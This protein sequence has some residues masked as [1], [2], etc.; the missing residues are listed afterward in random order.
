[1][2]LHYRYEL[3]LIPPAIDGKRHELGVELTKAATGEHKGVRLR[4]RPGV[5]S[6]SGGVRVGTLIFLWNQRRPV[7]NE[8]AGVLPASAPVVGCG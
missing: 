5:H 3:E 2:Q 8:G 4:Y 1:M 6:C 7:P